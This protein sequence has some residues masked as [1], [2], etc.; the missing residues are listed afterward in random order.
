M[1][2]LTRNTAFRAD[3]TMSTTNTIREDIVLALGSEYDIVREL[4]R[5][6]ASVVYLARDRVLGREVA[7]KVIRDAQTGDSEAIA[8]FQREA[9]TLASLQHPNIVMLYGAK[10]LPGGSLA[11]IMQHGEWSTLKAVIRE[12]GPLPIEAVEQVLHDLASALVYLHKHQVVHRDIKPENIFIEAETG[13]ALLSDFGIAKSGDAR[14]SV[15]LAGVVI[16]TPAYM[17]PEQ[18]DGGE[19]TGRSDLYSLGMVGYEML[20]G[21]RP[22]D[23]E[24]LFGVIYKQKTEKLPSLEQARPDASE[25]LRKL[26]EKATEKAPEARWPSAQELLRELVAEEPAVMPVTW[27]E[28]VPVAAQPE[29]AAPSEYPTLE[30][31]RALAEESFLERERARRRRQRLMVAAVIALLFSGGAGALAFSGREPTEDGA[32][33]TVERA[34]GQGIYLAE[35]AYA[36]SPAQIPVDTPQFLLDAPI[37][38]STEGGTVRREEPEGTSAPVTMSRG[39]PPAESEPVR[40]EEPQRTS[41]PVTRSRVAAP[42]ESEP[43]AD[44][45]PQTEL[46]ANP[47]AIR[48]G[49]SVSRR[50]ETAPRV[51]PSRT[52]EAR[53]TETATPPILRNREHVGQ[54]LSDRY[55]TDLRTRGIGGTTIVTVLVSSNGAVESSRVI[56]SSGNARLDQAALAVAARMQFAHEAGSANQPVWVAVPLTFTAP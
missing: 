29:H 42:A 8:R 55:P 27:A 6:G 2:E 45:A 54:L 23:G 11:L 47:P 22:W 3:E 33:G 21:T 51:E 30:I 18:I 4:G 40:R 44:S 24:S 34:D 39:A 38:A 35:T 25:R 13:H 32:P 12:Q 26:I 9:R 50:S 37:G 17:S 14:A 5:G 48:P 56:T 15:T 19:L 43:E 52:L 31:E 1:D 41:A 28:P 49:L 20:T 53:P 10:P 16:G 46:V 7:I 36:A